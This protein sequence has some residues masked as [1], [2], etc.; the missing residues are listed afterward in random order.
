MIFKV[1]DVTVY[2]PYDNIYP[3]Q[4]SNMVELKRALDAKGHCLLE[5]PTGTGKTIALFSLITVKLIYCTR[6]VHEMEKTLAELKLLHNYQTLHLCPA[7]K[8]LP[9]GLSSRKNLCVNSVVLAARIG[10]LSMPP[11][12]NGLLAGFVPWMLKIPMSKLVTSL[13]IMRRPLLKRICF[14][15]FILCRRLKDLR[16]FGK[17]K[18]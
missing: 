18:D 7:A 1:E 4:Y 11:V 6:T 5:M 12:E 10:T 8:I 17:Q 9:I 15:E 13:R 14:L 2:F 3:E 16:A